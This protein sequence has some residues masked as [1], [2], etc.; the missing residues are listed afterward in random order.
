MNQNMHK[1]R[2]PSSDTHRFTRVLRENG[3]QAVKCIAL[4]EFH[5]L[6]KQPCSLLVKFPRASQVANAAAWEA[7]FC[8]AALFATWQARQSTE[9]LLSWNL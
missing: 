4:Q 6:P 2:L 1:K 9:P 8:Q 3:V 7:R 5:A